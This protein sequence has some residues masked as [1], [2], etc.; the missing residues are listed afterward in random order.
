M[1]DNS[2]QDVQVLLLC[3]LTDLGNETIGPTF[4]E[5]RICVSQVSDRVV[6]FAKSAGKGL[7]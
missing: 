3:I 4:A 5:A 7:L 6:T 1:A 2:N